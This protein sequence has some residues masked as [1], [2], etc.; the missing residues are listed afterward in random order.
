MAAARNGLPF[1]MA[2]ERHPKAPLAHPPEGPR[3][4]KALYPTCLLSQPQRFYVGLI[5]TQLNELEFIRIRMAAK[6]LMIVI[7]L[8][9]SGV[10]GGGTFASKHNSDDRTGT[11]KLTRA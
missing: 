11:E 6:Q 2:A 4:H 8:T 5:F 7:M 3:A 1:G 9:C 10:P